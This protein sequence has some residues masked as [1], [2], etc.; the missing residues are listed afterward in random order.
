M[1]S[2]FVTRARELDRARPLG[3]KARAALRGVALAALARRPGSPAPGLRIV[4]YHFVFDDEVASFQ[5]QLAYFAAEFEPVSL[6]QAVDLLRDGRASGQELAVTFDDGFR[7]QLT[8]A[9][10]LLREAGFSACFFLITELVS[11]P[12]SD[13][14]R[15]CRERLHLP[16]P[17]EPL[18]WDDAAALLEQGHEVGSHTVTHP[19]LSTLAHAELDHELRASKGLIEQRLG[20]EVMHVSAPYG[21]AARFTP[22]VS[23]AARAAG[24]A[25]CATAVRGPNAANDVY[26]LRRDH[27]VAGWSVRDV[28]YFLSR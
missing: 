21:D 1:D 28:R 19:N 10:P 26:A 18:T 14:A 15:I 13:A 20:R 9:A 24:Y 7:N 6:T 27:V 12:D 3:A 8:N 2:R 11:A 4:H 25:S 5:R 23:D 16:R 22:A 17:V